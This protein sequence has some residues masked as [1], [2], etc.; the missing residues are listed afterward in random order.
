M[1]FLFFHPWVVHLPLALGVAMPLISLGVVLAWWFEWLPART[2][3]L[4]VALQVLLVVSGF[5]ALK[6]G[7]SAEQ[8]VER[9]VSRQV[10]EDHEATAE[11]FVWAAVGV[12]VLMVAASATADSSVGLPLAGVAA[13]GTLVVLA[14]GYRTGAEGGALVYRHGAASA[15]V[16]ADSSGAPGGTD[17][18]IARKPKRLSQKADDYVRP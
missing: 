2:W 10:I 12:L 14:F 5:A 8:R 11:T 3:I 9:V 7:E 13:A 6:S 1:D 17:G 4:A 16:D 18:R 15:Y